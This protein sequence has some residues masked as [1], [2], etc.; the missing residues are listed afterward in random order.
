MSTDTGKREDDQ[1]YRGKVG[2]QL[3]QDD[4]LSAWV[5]GATYA[6]IAKRLGYAT[7]AGAYNAVTSALTRH[8]AEAEEIAKVGRAVALARL[9]P[10]WNK[11]LANAISVDGGA[12][13][14]MAAAHIADRLARLEGVKDPAHEVRLTVETELDHE[15]TAL[16]DA[17]ARGGVDLGK[18]LHGATG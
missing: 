10:L 2:A 11:A 15:I 9:R 6:E 12:K 18:V 4:A 16:T 3:R 8:N 17:L 13:D 5:A 14:L 1:R 7:R